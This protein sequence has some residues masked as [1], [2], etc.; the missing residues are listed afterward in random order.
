[1]R[2]GPAAA[3]VGPL[4][5][6]PGSACGPRSRRAASRLVVRASKDAV[7]PD[8][9]IP[10][11]VITGFLG[12]GKTTLLNYIL[13]QPHGKRI[14][15]IE[16]EFGEIDIDSELVAR[17]EVLEGSGDSITV[18]SNG[19]LC[20]TVRDDLV[21]AL[22]NLWRRRDEFDHIVIETTGLA[23][24]GPIISS[25]Y[26]DKTLP[27]RVMLDGVVTVVDAVNIRRHL[28]KLGK[29]GN[30][31]AVNEAV[32][33]VAYADRVIINKTDL[34]DEAAV[35]ELEGR[36]RAINSLASM[37]R[38]TRSSVPLDYVL[39]IGGFDLEKVE[40]QMAPKASSSHS[41][42]HDHEHGPDCGPDC[43]HDHSHDHA[44]AHAH[45]HG[46]DCGPDCSNPDHD[47]SHEGA[48][49]HAHAHDH[50]HEHGADC[51][52]ECDNPEHNHSHSH[53]KLHDDQVSSLSFSVEGEMDLDKLNFTMGALLQA[54]G[55]DMY[56]MKGILAIKGLPDR[57]VFQ[58][59]HMLFEGTPERPWR[60]DE[61]R[62]SRMVFIGRELDR[63]TFQEVFSNCLADVDKMPSGRSYEERDKEMAARGA[64]V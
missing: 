9:R 55:E 48:H 64:A 36:L 57:Y 18:L 1:M 14:A 16:N 39:G 10:A 58:A 43:G 30:D 13:T 25:F 4:A 34:V 45:E 7:A 12:S 32:E 27:E 49:A 61:K 62:V 53:P 54:R 52:P 40:D 63:E 41:H 26:M 2:A 33:Q 17:K 60:D 20:C 6:T 38:A 5:P 47:H 29:E 8:D 44:H 56:R 50:A 46:A 21:A 3:P 28:D 59:V 42:S 35:D 15:V 23:N 22:N 19:C 11:T 37:T 51:G 24:P 31:D